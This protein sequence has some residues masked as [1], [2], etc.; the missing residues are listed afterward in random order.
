MT[1]EAINAVKTE[2][3]KEQPDAAVVAEKTSFL[4]EAVKWLGRKV[5]KAV[6]GFMGTIGKFGAA[7]FALWPIAEQVGALVT[8]LTRW[9]S[10]ILG[11][12]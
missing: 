5:D 11:V 2:L 7:S 6:D 1:E 4:H 12:R 3:E 9:L 8:M 10:M